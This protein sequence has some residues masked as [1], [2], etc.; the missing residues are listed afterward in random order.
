[1]KIQMQLL[2]YLLLIFQIFFV[3]QSLKNRVI[4][5]F[6]LSRITNSE[7]RWEVVLQPLSK[8]GDKL[9]IIYSPQRENSW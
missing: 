5:K 9:R 4:S 8:T 3:F 2:N 6:T 1:M 7:V